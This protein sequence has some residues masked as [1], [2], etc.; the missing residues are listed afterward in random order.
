MIRQPVQTKWFTW[1]SAGQTHKHRY[2]NHWRHKRS[3]LKIQISHLKTLTY[4][5]EQWEWSEKKTLKNTSQWKH[6]RTEYYMLVFSVLISYHCSVTPT[7]TFMLQ[8]CNKWY[9][10]QFRLSD[11][12]ESVLVKPISVDTLVG[13]A[14][15]RLRL[16][17]LDRL[18]G[19]IWVCV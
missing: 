14:K 8:G 16:E 7:V 6:S 5:C 12:L 15:F 4:R 10:N 9:D 13:W 1:V 17:R 18:T 2:G 3:G 11:L 19:A